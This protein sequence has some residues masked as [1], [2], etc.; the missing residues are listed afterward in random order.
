[1][2]KSKEAVLVYDK[3]AESYANEFS[4]PS[5]YIDEFLNLL[6]KGGKILDVGCGVGVDANHMVSKGFNVIGIDLSDEMLKLAKR[7]FPNIKF[8]KLDMRE[9][10]FELES[11]HGIFVAFSLIHIPKKDV[12]EVL[13]KLY[14][15][16]KKEGLIYIAI[17]EG[18]S[19]EISVTVP[20]KPNEKLFL[21]IYSSDEIKN[22]VKKADFSIIN[23]YKRE[24]KSKE[25]LDFIK[26]FLL[27]KK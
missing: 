24:R 7:K 13:S 2:D 19:Q 12:P 25:E 4:N 1:M 26:Y 11:F 8:E 15:F 9:L 10:S 3:I 6:T 14:G 23:E 17:Q 16:L 22:L 27:V 5:D 20:L 18:E 21:N